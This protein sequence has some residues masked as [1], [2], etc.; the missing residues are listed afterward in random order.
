[1]QHP[2][3]LTPVFGQ[4]GIGTEAFVLRCNISAASRRNRRPIRTHKPMKIR[5]GRKNVALQ[6]KSP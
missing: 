4:T 1:L 6:Q 5:G 2:R 3:A